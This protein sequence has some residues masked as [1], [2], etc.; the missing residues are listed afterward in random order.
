MSTGALV[1]VRNVEMA[2]KVGRHKGKPA[3]LQVLR[4]LSLDVARGETLGLVGESGSG[5]STAARVVVGLHEPTAGTVKLFGRLITGPERKLN[6]AAVRSRT[7][8]VFQD[9]QAALDPRMRVG[10]SVAEPIDVAGAHTRRDRNARVQEL[11]AM[12]GLPRDAAD[13]FPH[14]FSGGQRQ[15]IVIARALALEPA[16]IVCD[17]PV[18]ALDV[19]MQAQVVNLLM[20][21]Q[22][23]FGIGYLF[24]AHDLGVVRAIADRVAVIYSGAIVEV[25][26]K[27]ALYSE[28]AHPYTRALL[29]AVPRPDPARARTKPIAGEVPSL[30]APPPGCRFHARCPHVMPRCQV[31]EP[32]LR[33]V[34]P[35]RLAACHLYDTTQT[36]RAAISRG[37]KV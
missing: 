20:D 2:F 16:F 32:V 26:R 1:E 29:D 4:D 12:V 23:R 17:E 13:R 37:L 30:F 3:R 35:A 10:D 14:E 8:F 7:Q 22:A 21:L 11:L 18:S 24:I 33:E 31:E 25:A 34:A 15:R 27:D 5:K 6:L 9:P 28:P 19:S 36:P